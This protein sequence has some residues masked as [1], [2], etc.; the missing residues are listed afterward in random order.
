VYQTYPENINPIEG[1][2]NQN[3]INWMKPAA[4][5]GFRKLLGHVS[6]TFNN[7][8]VLSFNII[9]NFQVRSFDASKYIVVTQLMGGLGQKNINLGIAYIVLGAVSLFIAFLFAVKQFLFPRDKFEHPLLQGK[10]FR[11]YTLTH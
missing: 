9:N 4:F 6:G 2:T 8:D 7:G 5:P 1:I 10:R 3:F 11:V